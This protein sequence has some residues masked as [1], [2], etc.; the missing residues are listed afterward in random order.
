[1]EVRQAESISSLLEGKGFYNYA[2]ITPSAASTISKKLNAKVFVIGSIKKDGEKIRLNAQVIDSQTDE[3]L[4]SFEI[5]GIS[6]EGDIFKL[7]DS[8]RVMVKNYL[9]ISLMKKKVSPD[10]ISFLGSTK[11]PEALRYFIDGQKTFTKRDY[12]AAIDLFLSALKA[13]SNYFNPML[14]ISIAYGNR[15]MY[16]DAKKWCL[17]APGKLIGCQKLIKSGQNMPMLYISEN[18]RMN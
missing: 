2:S 6:I 7:T 17:K 4:R 5:E 14:F 13:D 10:I 8:L 9:I 16:T 15:G 1:M 3:T 12:P 18:H 11:S